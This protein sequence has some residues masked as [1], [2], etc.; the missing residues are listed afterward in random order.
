LS[1]ITIQPVRGNLGRHFR[2]TRRFSFFCTPRR[3]L[4]S[5]AL[6]LILLAGYF[7][8]LSRS[9][10][11]ASRLFLSFRKHAW[12]LSSIPRC[13]VRR[14]SSPDPSRPR[15]ETERGQTI[16]NRSSCVGRLYHASGGS[17]PGFRLSFLELS[18]SL[19][20]ITDR[21]ISNTCMQYGYNR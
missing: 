1:T 20:N 21:A 12:L 16:L 5:V 11:C 13:I 8:I 18:I 3:Y 4:L 10:L 17:Q 6:N 14:C 2:H 15:E 19:T 9:S 7:L